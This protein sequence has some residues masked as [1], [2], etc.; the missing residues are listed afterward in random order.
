ML[1]TITTT[2][3]PATDLGYLLHKHPDRVQK[4]KLAFGKAHVFYPEAT[5]ER[6]T[7]ALLME[8][9]PVDLVRGR[10]RQDFALKQYVNDRPYVA[11]SF[12]SVA[13]AQVLGTALNG[14]CKDRPLLVKTPIPLEVTLAAV[15]CQTGEKLL[16]DLF[17]PL[18]Y[19]V[20]TA[21]MTLDERFPEWGNSHI[22]QLTLAQTITLAEL[23]T[24]LYVL[25]PVL[26]NEKHYYVGDHEV[27]KLLT[28]GEGWLKEHPL[29]E[30]IIRRY[31]KYQR[32]LQ[33]LAVERLTADD[34][35]AD[36]EVEAQD[37]EEAM[38]EWP[39]SLH[40]Q[41]LAAV[42]QVLKDDGAQRVLDLGCGEG[43]L[44]Q[45]LLKE[46]HFQKIVGVDVST[47]SLE[48]AAQRLHLDRLSERQRQRIQLIQGSLTY[49][50]ARLKGYDAAAV[51][52]VIEHLEPER[53]AAFERALFEFARPNLI[54]L[55]TPNREYNA[56][57]ET[58]PAG[59][60]RHRDH[61]FEW[62]RA[63]FEA[64]TADVGT[65]FGYE[66]TIKPVGPVEDQLGA[67]SQMAVFRLG[68][69]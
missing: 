7:A 39:L 51:V 3:Q 52:E 11:S 67:P 6:C 15:P 60:L 55:T 31:L 37:Q 27:D 24:H 22:Y 48:R 13:I 12:L 23:L 38:L 64:W 25:I 35:P 32:S 21:R 53:L 69:G 42:F 14:R 2:H 65:R 62:T 19:R 33:R 54:V 49:R 68:E 44:L 8:I 26:D 36:N 28:K 57:W 41:R 16:Y 5:A 61:R 40:Q 63:E 20:K 10:K 50:D 58:L 18:G 43:Q 59:T 30:V 1:L 66:V 29:R 46:P 4:F 34:P 56:V 45:R 17:E 9:N 47:L